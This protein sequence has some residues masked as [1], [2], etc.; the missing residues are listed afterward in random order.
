MGVLD[1]ETVRLRMKPLKKGG[2]SLYL[3]IYVKGVRR[4]EFLRLYLREE[5]SY[6]DK[7]ENERTLQLANAIKGKRLVEV[8]NNHFGFSNSKAME[9]ADFI[10]YMRQNVRVNGHGT[11]TRAIVGNIIKKLCEYSHRRAIPFKM[12]DKQF[13]VGFADF[14]RECKSKGKNNRQFP[15]AIPLA[16]KTIYNYFSIFAANLRRAYQDGLIPE[17]P[18]MRMRSAD[19]PKNPA[20]D[21]GFL[22]EDEVRRLYK[23]PCKHEWIKTIFL[24]GCTTGLRLSDITT[25]EWRHLTDDGN[26]VIICKKKQM[27]T[28]NTVEFPLS[29]AAVKLLPQRPTKA[30]GLVFGWQC[31]KCTL[32]RWLSKWVEDAGIKK[33]VTFHMSRHTFATL[34][35]TKGADLYVVSKLMGHSDISSTQI[36]AKVVDERKRQASELMPEF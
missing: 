26:G 22:T 27:K 16:E 33:H 31:D 24:F 19:I 12:I 3:D 34:M 18:V 14:L 32:Y 25:L 13:C 17:N 10:T 29:K 20:T 4:Y 1:K 28:D 36:Y 2:A 8:Q 35:L 11:G 6:A 15:V 9:N 23:T 30:T 21:R 7:Q 5:L